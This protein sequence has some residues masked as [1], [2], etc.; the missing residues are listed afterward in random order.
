MNRQK[1]LAGSLSVWTQVGKQETYAWASREVTAN[2]NPGHRSRSFEDALIGTILRTQLL[3]L[4][5]T[6]TSS[7]IC[8]NLNRLESGFHKLPDFVMHGIYHL[9][10]VIDPN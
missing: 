9:F 1:L 6:H 7:V 3:V 5:D 4:S 10:A 8:E 2:C